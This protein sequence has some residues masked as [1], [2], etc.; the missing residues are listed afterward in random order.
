MIRLSALPS[1]QGQ[2][3]KCSA[4]I[5]PLLPGTTMRLAAAQSISVPG[6]VPANVLIHLQFIAAAQ[7]A[8]VDLLVFP[9]LSLGGDELPLLAGCPVQPGRARLAPVREQGSG[10]GLTVF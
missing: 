5:F 8:G 1:W 10:G 4:V 3:K 2:V 6:D 9:E 7:E